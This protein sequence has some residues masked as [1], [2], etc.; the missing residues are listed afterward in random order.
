MA[1][2]TIIKLKS[3]EVH[4][5][6]TEFGFV[7]VQAGDAMEARQIAAQ[8]Q[9]EGNVQWGDEEIELVGVVRIKGD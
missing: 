5:K 9:L 6:R 3:F 4:V 2:E 8:Q 7:R 1:E